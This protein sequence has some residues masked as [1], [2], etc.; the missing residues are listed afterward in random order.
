M[1]ILYVIAPIVTFGCGSILIA[2]SDYAAGHGW[3]RG[4]LFE[5][6]AILRL[7]GFG[8]MAWALYLSWRLGWPHVAATVVGGLVFSYVAMKTL[9]G[10]SQFA[11]LAGPAAGVGAGLLMLD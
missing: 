1:E 11:L 10:W 6:P 3:A 8:V 7:V 5:R 2:Y 4:V 9:R